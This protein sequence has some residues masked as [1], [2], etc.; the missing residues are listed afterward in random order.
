MKTVPYKITQKTVPYKITQKTVPYKITQKTVST[1]LHRR[2]FLQDNIEDSSYKI[3]QKTVPIRLHRIQDYIEDSPYKI[4]W[5]HLMYWNTIMNFNFQHMKFHLLQYFSHQIYGYNF[6]H[7]RYLDQ[8]YIQGG[9]E[10]L[11]RL[12]SI[13]NLLFFQQH[14]SLRPTEDTVTYGDFHFD[15]TFLYTLISLNTRTQRR[16]EL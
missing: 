3:T 4:T 7:N 14:N 9:K 11:Y 8:D 16:P 12:K 1:R 6:E 13:T 2:E 15:C 5:N 10:F